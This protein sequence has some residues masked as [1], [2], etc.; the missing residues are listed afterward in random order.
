MTEGPVVFDSNLGKLIA[1]YIEEMRAVGYKYNKSSSLLKRF[2]TFA[3]KENLME[4]KLPK[5]LVL[6]W[7][8]KKPNETAST[9][10]VSTDIRSQ[11]IRRSC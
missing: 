7:T 10:T 1:G 4:Q 5:E 3:A 11:R 6:L 2:D 8:E 9:R